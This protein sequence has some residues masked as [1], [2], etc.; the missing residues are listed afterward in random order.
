[1][2]AFK[3]LTAFISLIFLLAVAAFADSHFQKT[4]KYSPDMFTDVSASAWYYSEVSNAYELGFINGKGNGLM[5][6]DGEVTVAEAV[7]IASRVNAVYFGRSKELESE[8]VSGEW[9][10]KYFSYAEKYGLVQKGQYNS[11]TR[12]ARRYEVALLFFNALPKEYFEKINDIDEIPDVK[13]GDEFFSQLITL[14]RAGVVLGSDDYGYF[15]PNASIKRCEI[16]AIVN[17]AAL[18]ENRLHGSLAENKW[19][20]NAQAVYLI[21]DTVMLRTDKK[22]RSILTHGWICDSRGSE[23][24]FKDG[25]TSNTLYDGSDKAYSA[26][27]KYITPQTDSHLVLDTRLTLMNGQNGL[28]IYFTDS[29]DNSVIEI[30]TENGKFCLAGEQKLATDVPV[31]DKSYA[32]RLDMSLAD[33]LATLYI[34]GKKTV[35]AKI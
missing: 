34:D 31:S 11:L 16:A 13:Q 10:S 24:L 27:Y 19:D 29:E 20:N 7:T 4:E 30:A 18:P 5:S 15:H 8:Q 6:P 12:P 33:R 22:N 21:D 9:Y 25:S 17:R 32:L 1:M 28:R 3:I 2:K 14:Y 35:S 26:I 23:S